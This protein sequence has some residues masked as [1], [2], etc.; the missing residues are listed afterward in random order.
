MGIAARELADFLHQAT[1]AKLPVIQYPAKAARPDK[2]IRMEVTEKDAVPQHPHGFLIAPDG[3]HGLC[4]RSRSPHGVLYGV[5]A[6]LKKAAGCRWYA[7]DETLVPRHEVL[8]L[9]PVYGVDSPVFTYR[10]IYAHEVFFDRCW[11]Q[12]QRLNSG[13]YK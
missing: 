11:A 3:E 12:R 5:Y 9:P 4:I 2:L 6:F 10:D 8:R 7:P 1:G 13:C